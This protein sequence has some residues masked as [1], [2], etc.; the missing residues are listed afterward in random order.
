MAGLTP[1]F[2]GKEEAQRSAGAFGGFCRNDKSVVCADD[3]VVCADEVMIV[4]IFLIIK[5]LRFQ[6]GIW[7]CP[8]SALHKK[9]FVPHLQREN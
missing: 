2:F 9:D 3:S 7:L 6:I 8:F 1:A 5:Y 4:K